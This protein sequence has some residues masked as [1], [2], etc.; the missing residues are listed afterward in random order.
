MVCR[1]LEFRGVW[2]LGFVLGLIVS[3]FSRVACSL[4]LKSYARIRRCTTYRMKHPKLVLSCYTYVSACAYMQHVCV[5]IY[6]YI[7]MIHIHI[8]I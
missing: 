7:Y 5:Y 3:G 6:I 4:S 8:Y 1:L 2:G